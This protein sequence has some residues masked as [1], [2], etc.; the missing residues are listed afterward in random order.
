MLEI[1]KILRVMSDVKKLIKEC[2]KYISKLSDDD[3]E[4]VSDYAAPTDQPGKVSF[5]HI[6]QQLHGTRL[7]VPKKTFTRITGRLDKII[8]G[9]PTSTKTIKLY[10]GM[11][12][13]RR[14][15]LDLKVG[16]IF[17]NKGYSST[18]LN[19]KAAA[20]FVST[21]EENPKYKGIYGAERKA[22]FDKIQEPYIR[23]LKKACCL[24]EIK[25]PPGIPLL[26]VEKNLSQFAE[27]EVILQRDL[28]LEFT[29]NGEKKLK[30]QRG[31]SMTVRVFKFEVSK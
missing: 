21:F 3:K 18:S 25:V 19:A 15:Q 27:D 29:G 5:E 20:N 28:I 1:D 17:V 23:S 12:V 6:N 22:L 26:Y 8:A 10:R 16:E 7:D 30:N 2:E 14:P 31:E 9:A 4:I 13:H 24:M 11:R